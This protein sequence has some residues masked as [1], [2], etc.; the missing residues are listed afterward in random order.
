MFK[1]HFSF[2]SSL[3]RIGECGQSNANSTSAEWGANFVLAVEIGNPAADVRVTCYRT[4]HS[5]HWVP[6]F[7]P[8]DSAFRKHRS[9][10]VPTMPST[11]SKPFSAPPRHTLSRSCVMGE[12]GEQLA[13][14]QRP[15]ARAI[16]ADDFQP[17][18][19]AIGG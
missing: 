4:S 13:F 6:V 14:D 15:V 1:L 11:G 12:A 10:D 19:A 5:S 16:V 2:A 17:A 18:I 3:D 7:H 9:S 8:V